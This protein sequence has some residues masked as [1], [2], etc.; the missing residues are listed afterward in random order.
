VISMATRGDVDMVDATT[1][2]KNP[3][4][5]ADLLYTNHSDA[6]AFSQTEQLALGLYDKLI[7]LELE[8]SL[9]AAQQSSTNAC[10]VIHLKY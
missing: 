5:Y 4:D 6:F 2:V 7:E 10:S 1:K 3:N 9:I 8:Q